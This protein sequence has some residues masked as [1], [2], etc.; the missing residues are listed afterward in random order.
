M[1]ERVERMTVFHPFRPFSACSPY[2]TP[3]M[4]RV[5]RVEHI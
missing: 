4:E 2:E 5:E 1:L 3:Y